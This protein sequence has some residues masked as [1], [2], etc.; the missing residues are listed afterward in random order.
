[1]LTKIPPLLDPTWLIVGYICFV[2]YSEEGY[3][4]LLA[5]LDCGLDVNLFLYIVIV[6]LL[7]YV[8]CFISPHSTHPSTGISLILPIKK[9]CWYC[10]ALRDVQYLLLQ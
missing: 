3:H 4:V 7:A 8:A 2:L 5:L 10:I 6:E 9:R 1:M